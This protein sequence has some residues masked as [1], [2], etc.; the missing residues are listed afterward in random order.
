MHEMLTIV[1][2]VRGVCLSVCPSVRQSVCQFVT[3]LNS[4]AMRA[5]CEGSFGAAFAELL[6][7]FVA[8]LQWGEVASIASHA[9]RSCYLLDIIRKVSMESQFV[10]K[11]LKAVVFIAEFFLHCTYI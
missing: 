8:M 1:T 7:P 2:D 10:K 11:F 6:W 4:A 3:R 5:V 9:Q